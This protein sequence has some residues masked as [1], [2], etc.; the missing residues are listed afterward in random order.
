MNRSAA[1][2]ASD[3]DAVLLPAAAAGEAASKDGINSTP[4]VFIDGQKAEGQTLADIAEAMVGS[5][6]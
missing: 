3:A 6:N 4:T 2:R 5:A 1:T